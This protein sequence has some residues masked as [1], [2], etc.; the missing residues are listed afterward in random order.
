MEFSIKTAIEIFGVALLLFVFFIM[1]VFIYKVTA[2][3]D[4]SIIKSAGGFFYRVICKSGFM[5]LLIIIVTYIICRS[6]NDRHE[7]HV[8]TEMKVPSQLVSK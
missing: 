1:G 4:K 5:V 6:E 8:S 7:K 3:I 2:S